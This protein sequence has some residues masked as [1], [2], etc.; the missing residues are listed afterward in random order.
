MEFR[1]GFAILARILFELGRSTA[2]LA[3]PRCAAGAS[4]V[5]ASQ[6]Y[7]LCQVLHRVREWG[8][9]SAAAARAGRPLTALALPPVPVPAFPDRDGEGLVPEKLLAASASRRLG[10]SGQAVRIAEQTRGL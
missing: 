4:W 9:G 8:V 5:C 2:L 10:N 7:V 6:A 1:S 3:W